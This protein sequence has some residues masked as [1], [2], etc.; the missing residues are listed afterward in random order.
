MKT[1]TEFA[2]KCL[3]EMN[4]GELSTT[5]CVAKYLKLWHE[6]KTKWLLPKDE[7][8]VENRKIIFKL[9]GNDIRMG[10]FL[11]KD[12]WDRP[13]RFCDG[14]FHEAENVEGWFYVPNCA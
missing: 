13:N 3:H 2:N 1:I 4:F 8:P 11:V 5:E 12:Q 6:E 7:L 9:K 14:A 10:I